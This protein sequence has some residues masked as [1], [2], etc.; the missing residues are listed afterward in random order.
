MAQKLV[1]TIADFATTLV[2]KVA[3]GATSGTLVSGLD[4][5]GIQLPTGTY[6]FTIDRNNSAK[7]H[8]TATLTGSA[9]TNIQTVTRGTGVGTSGLLRVH[10]KGA[11][12]IISD[13]VAIKRMMN[14]LDATTSFD[15]ASPLG[16]DA[17]P[18]LT[19]GDTEKFATVRYANGI[20]TAGAPDSSTT[21][22]GIVKISTAPVS[23]SS[24]IAVGDN[25]TRVPTQ[26]ENNAMVGNNTDIAVGSGNLNVTQTGFQKG[27]EIYA[28]DA[29]SNDTYVITLSPVPISYYTG[30]IFRFKANTVNTG[31]ATLN[32]NSL[33][34]KTIVKGISTT[35]ADGDIAVGQFCTVQYD[36]ANFVLISPLGNSVSATIHKNGI[37][38]YDIN[39][40]SGTQNI[41]HGLGVV[42]KKV[43]ITAYY[44]GAIGVDSVSVITV[45]N[46][47]TQSSVGIGGTNTSS[48][49]YLVNTFLLSIVSG[50][51]AGAS[52]ILTFDAT[53]IIITWTKI[54]SPGSITFNLMWEAEV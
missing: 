33:G 34:A 35:L 44:T 11:E 38:T 19:S 37:T 17:D 5:D 3:V 28:A 4:A 30:Q 22:K 23:P 16:Y 20:S 6:G 47:T 18:G 29:G 45:Y 39:T 50:A 32:V 9:L 21:V 25:D 51:S 14:V 49:K 10:R 53:N 48:G 41:A 26:G 36:G 7:E 40:A 54:G 46:G 15:S 12:V 52:G 42:P 27:A 24:P 8:F 31:A 2:S 13:H 1:K 43:K